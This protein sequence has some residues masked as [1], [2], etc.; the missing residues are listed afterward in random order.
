[1]G[2][3]YP[4]CRE[5]SGST[6]PPP[7]GPVALPCVACLPGT[8]PLEIQVQISGMLDRFSFLCEHC[9]LLNSTFILRQVGQ[10]FWR[11]NLEP[12]CGYNRMDL[13]VLAVT[14][15]VIWQ[16]NVINTGAAGKTL[17]FSR[18]VSGS[19]AQCDAVAISLNPLGQ[20]GDC[21]HQH[22][23]VSITAL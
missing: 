16:L 2:G 11:L 1:M 7:A 18:S 21:Q 6:Q 14:S 10:C 3:G 12:S 4:C 19:P 20:P 9:D 17:A 8:T 22:S 15:G 13:G 23:A 5:A